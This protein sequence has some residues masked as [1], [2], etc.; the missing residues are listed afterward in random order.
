[1]Y[2]SPCIHTNLFWP[3]TN[4]LISFYQQA[5]TVDMPL[6]RLPNLNYQQQSISPRNVYIKLTA[7]H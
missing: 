5:W 2:E 4:I 6:E 3:L 1:M 7:P